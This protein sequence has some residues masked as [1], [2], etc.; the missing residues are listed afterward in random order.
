[1]E[2]YLLTLTG[3]G[4]KV[5]QCVM[6]F[7]MK[8]TETFPVDVWMRRVMHRFYGCPEDDE[9]GMRAFAAEKFGD[10]AGIAQMYLFHYIRVLENSA[11]L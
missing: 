4:P 1:M 3:I 10:I 2:K 11:E 6:L 5:A 9:A 8:R 7:S